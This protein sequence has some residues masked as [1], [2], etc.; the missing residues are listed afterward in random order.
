MSFVDIIRFLIII[1]VLPAIIF[2]RSVYKKDKIEKEPIELIIKLFVLGGFSI[3]VAGIVE[4]IFD[5]AVQELQI[6]NIP[7]I[8][9]LIKAFVVV[10]LIEELTKFLILKLSTWKNSNFNYTFDAIVYAVAV[11][12]GFAAFENILYVFIGGIFT[13]VIRALTAIPAHMTFAVLMGIY[14]GRAKVCENRND[15]LG[16]RNNLIKSLGSS[17][18]FHG[19]YD[20][21][22]FEAN[23]IFI[24]L[25]I[26]LLI[27]IYVI[28][29]KNI[30]KYSNVDSLV[31]ENKSDED[32]YSKYMMEED[33][34]KY[35]EFAN[36]DDFSKFE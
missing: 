23:P 26:V 35:D 29:F 14:Y 24:I 1:S 10:A 7:I 18:L 36:Y 22:L 8:Y 12:L 17:V 31:C 6:E 33:F 21:C 9:N 15:N 16:K 25:F 13:S 11:G 2:M 3:I 5:D 20:F 30:E 27:I 34:S 4:L 28:L 19:L 32:V